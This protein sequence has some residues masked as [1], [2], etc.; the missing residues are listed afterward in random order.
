[1][2]APPINIR[3]NFELISNKETKY[4]IFISKMENSLKIEAETINK[5]P[6]ISYQQYFNFEA[7]KK[8]R[9]FKHCDTIDEVLEEI[10]PQIEEKD[11]KLIED[12][13][14]IKLIIPLPS[15]VIKEAIFNLNKKTKKPEDEIIELYTIIN[16]LKEQIEKNEREFKTI[17]EEKNNK[18]NSLEQKLNNILS[19]PFNL[20]NISE[21]NLINSWLNNKEYKVKLL[22]KL[23]RDGDKSSDFHRLCD[24]QGI[25]ITFI[26]TDKKYFFGGYTE[27][28]WDTSGNYKNDSSTFIFSFNLSH[29]FTKISQE[30]SIYCNQNFGPCFGY[31]C[32]IKIQ[33][34]LEKGEILQY[35][36]NDSF[37][38]ENKQI[39][40][41]QQQFNILE[42]EVYKLE[43]L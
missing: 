17:I 42:I 2:T 19:N 1:M 31:N 20:C 7:I 18:I 41:K 37:I 4:N 35:N 38:T 28:N 33:D 9:F 13:V 11:T 40:G 25:T 5:I 26:L 14:Y 30:N 6:I 15:K 3:Q 21:Y 8:N 43:Y 12:E 32:N 27:L 29:K 10:L 39:N 22:F 34:D 23:T 24:N 16:K 36:R